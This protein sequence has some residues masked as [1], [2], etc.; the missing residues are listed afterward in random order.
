MMTKDMG[1]LSPYDKSFG[2]KLG[3][4]GDSVTTLTDTTPQR[5][6]LRMLDH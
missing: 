6:D 2:T 4:E 5:V 1:I 3:Q